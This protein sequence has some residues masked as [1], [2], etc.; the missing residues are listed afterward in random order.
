MRS[1]LLPLLLGLLGQSAYAAH[2]LVTDDTSTQD[3]GN[4]QIEANTDRLRQPGGYT[5]IGTLT[6][7]YGV[8]RNLDIFINAPMTFSSPSGV[9]DTGLGAKWRLVETDTAS[10]ALKAELLLP[11]GDEKKDLGNGLVSTAFT[12]IGSYEAAPWTLHGN[13]AAV[14][15]RYALQSQRDEHHH[16]TL[17]RISAAAWYAV[18]ER[19]RLVADIGI[20]RK[21]EKNGDANPGYLLVGAIYS[22]LDN[23]DLDAGWRVGLGCGECAAQIKRQFG[24][25]VTWRF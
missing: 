1:K 19:W 15:N 21:T 16:S 11:A 23:L 17:W 25:G 8:L 2:P 12:L 20:A 13:V 3:Q 5:S 18:T 4:S 22:P 24:L 14:F 6:Y 7:S 10:M 9:N